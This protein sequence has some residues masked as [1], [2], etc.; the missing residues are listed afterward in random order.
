MMQQANTRQLIQI[1][2]LRKAHQMQAGLIEMI[3]EVTSRAPAPSGTG[4][5]IGKT[6]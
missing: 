5:L 4:R 3:D 2:A 6:A 1:A